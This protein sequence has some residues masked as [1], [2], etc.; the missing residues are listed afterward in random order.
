M[1][2]RADR[3]TLLLVGPVLALF[4]VRVV[5]LFWWST[6]RPWHK[7]VAQKLFL[8]PFALIICP[9]PCVFV[10][11]VLDRCTTTRCRGTKTIGGTGNDNIAWITLVNAGV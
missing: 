5:E 8:I 3:L 10:I 7:R 11:E 4:D 9:S 2:L 6:N 1:N